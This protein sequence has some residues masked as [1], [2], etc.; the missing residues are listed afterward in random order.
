LQEVWR[1]LHN[2]ELYIL[3]SSPNIVRMISLRRIKYTGHVACEGSR[4]MHIGFWRESQKDKDHSE[5]LDVG[6]RVI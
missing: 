2:C 3:Y 1:K 4:E 5:D 6:G